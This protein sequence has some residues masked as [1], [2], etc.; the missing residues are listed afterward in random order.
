MEI[1]I[2]IIIYIFAFM[3]LFVT[4]ITI[5]GKYIIINEKTDDKNYILRKNSIKIRY[6]KK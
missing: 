6:H 5:F 2:N 1:L 4:G 3:G